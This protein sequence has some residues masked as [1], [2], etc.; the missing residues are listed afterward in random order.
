VVA[1]GVSAIPE[2]VESGRT[3]WLVPPGRPEALADGMH[4]MLTDAGLRRRVIPAARQ[5]VL[6]DFD[7]RALVARLADIYRAALAGSQGS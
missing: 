7:N 6:R 3:G 2:L 1:T 4:A 5:R